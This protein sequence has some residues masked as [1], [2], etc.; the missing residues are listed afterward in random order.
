MLG[1]ARLI[2]VHKVPA[3][4]LPV[5]CV[6]N[7][8]IPARRI[9]ERGGQTFGEFAPSYRPADTLVGHLRF[10]LRY[11]GLNLQV[12]KLLF[13]RLGG[14][15]IRAAL[16]EQPESAVARRLAFL[17]EWLTRQDLDI[18]EGHSGRRQYV[19][20]LDEKLQFGMQRR[21]P[22]RNEKFRVIDNLPGTP[23]FCP[24][25][26]R[27]AYLQRMS[28]KGLA[29]LAAAKLAGYDRQLLLRAA[30][31]LYLKE[32]Q[33][34]FEVE[35]ETPSTS[36]AQ[37]FAD[38]LQESE[39][40]HELTMERLVDLQNAVVDH[41]FQ[42]ASW[43]QTQN[44]LGQ[45]LGYRKKVAFVPPR[46][47]DVHSLMDGLMA[48]SHRLRDAH[49]EMK[50]AAANDSLAIDPVVAAAS[51]SF[52]FVFI[53]PFLDGNGRIHR[54]LIHEQLSNYGF[55]PKG[56]ILPVS[57]VIVGNLD[58]YE[59]A[60]TAFSSAIMQRTNFDAGVPGAVATGN[61]PLYFRYFDATEQASFL[62]DALER[63][64]EKDLDQEISFLIGFDRAREALNSIADWPGQSRDLFINLVRQ[65][66]GRLSETKRKSQF[67]HLEDAEITRFEG[68][69]ERAFDL[70]IPKTEI[71]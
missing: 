70:K 52:G 13:D 51:I 66:K 36:R 35:R 4:P 14:E 32:T 62:Y 23:A 29:Q 55:T 11:E 50:Q 40:G 46:P 71:V 27:T 56:F 2:Q 60:L 22:V 10:A 48:M 38:L 65:N 67:P 31:H 54:Y 44:W 28:Q 15:E 30:G 8:S 41:R 45:D 9:Q 7:E 34:S 39:A 21:K 17:C 1:Y 69:V 68:I 53:H 20:V 47:E 49:L 61:D 25:V 12:L 63:T 24:L 59:A 37:R 26:R 3:L 64:I 42:E 16:I 18:P 33:S 19:A 43:R 5:T 6:I 57:A 58:R